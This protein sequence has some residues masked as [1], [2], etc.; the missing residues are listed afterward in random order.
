[1]EL[2][3]LFVVRF[4]AK[5]CRTGCLHDTELVALVAAEGD[6]GTFDVD[7]PQR[8]L[9]CLSLILG[10]VVQQLTVAL[11]KQVPLSFPRLQL[12]ESCTTY[13]KTLTY[14]SFTWSKNY[15]DR[16]LDWY[17][18]CDPD[19]VPVYTGYSLFNTTKCITLLFIVQ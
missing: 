19:D 9:S 4:F 10:F 8:L 5:R 15:L 17:L 6:G 7:G 16:D 12:P 3:L 14:T 13:S 18:D 11:L 1:M 2:R